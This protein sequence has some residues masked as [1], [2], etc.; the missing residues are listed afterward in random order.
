MNVIRF[1]A[2]TDIVFD[3]RGVREYA[4]G[5]GGGAAGGHNADPG[6]VVIYNH[7]LQ[8]AADAG[9]EAEVKGAAM[10]DRASMLTVIRRHC[11]LA[12][13]ARCGE[14]FEPAYAD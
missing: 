5:T 1:D 14:M 8:Y 12:R 3:R 13:S 11:K 9:F 2:T 10:T 4:S 6:A 7:E